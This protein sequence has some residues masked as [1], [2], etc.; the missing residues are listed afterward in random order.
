M[1]YDYDESPCQGIC[2]MVNGEC[3]GCGRSRAEVAKWRGLS[4]DEK[5]QVWDRLKVTKGLEPSGEE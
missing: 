4:T 2:D 1:N 5:K 3:R